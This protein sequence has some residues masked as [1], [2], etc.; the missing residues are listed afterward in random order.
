MG[1]Q[2]PQRRRIATTRHAG[3][4]LVRLSAV[5]QEL[6]APCAFVLVQSRGSLALSREAV[7]QTIACLD[8]L[9]VC[10]KVTILG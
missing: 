2:R 7:A 1:S 10:D 6:L 5:G 3:Q 9:Y 4:R 8:F